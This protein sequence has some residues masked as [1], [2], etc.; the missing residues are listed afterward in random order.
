MDTGNDRRSQ[1]RTRTVLNGRIVFNHRGSLINCVVRDLSPGGARI[2]FPT[3]FEPPPV[4]ELEVP[5]K[6]LC[7]WSQ[8]VWS[9]GTNHGVKFFAPPADEEIA[10]LTEAKALRIE[11]VLQ[12][13]R[14][15]IAKTVGV[16][17]EL[18]HISFDLL[19]KKLT[20]A[21][22]STLRPV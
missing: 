19:S 16:A 9:S 20:R 1:P 11:K 2:E 18:V 5:S 21:A 14:C 22:G 13:A 3:A 6:N 8:R 17:P 4:F 7:A 15:E 10:P 12:Q